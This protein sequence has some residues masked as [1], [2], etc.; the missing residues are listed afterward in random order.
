[1]GDVVAQQGRVVDNPSEQELI[2]FVD[3]RK[4]GLGFPTYLLKLILHTIVDVS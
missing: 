1:M 4:M 3:D 2:L